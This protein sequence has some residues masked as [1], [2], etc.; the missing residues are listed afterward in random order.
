MILITVQH[1]LQMLLR[2][3]DVL[4]LNRHLTSHFTNINSLRQISCPE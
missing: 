1:A 2:F 4:F 3:S